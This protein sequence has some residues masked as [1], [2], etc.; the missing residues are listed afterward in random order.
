MEKI[1]L[2]NFVPKQIISGKNNKN[3]DINITDDEDYLRLNYSVD[4]H[5]QTGIVGKKEHYFLLPKYIERNHEMFEVLGLLQAEMGKTNNG[6][7]N[8]CN[9]EIEIIKKVVRWFEREFDFPRK[10]WKWYIK[11]NINEP[12]DQDYKKEVEDKVSNYWIKQIGLSLEQ[13][14]PKK[15]SYV[16]DTKNKKLKFYDYG[17]LIIERKLNLFS[18]IIKKLVKDI[19]QNILNYREEE[20]RSF[21]RGI[22]GG[23]SCIEIHKSSKKYRIHITSNH[24]EERDIYISCLNRL[25]IYSKQYNN[26]KD[27]IISRKENH[28]KLFEQ[29]LMCTSRKK[30]NKFLKLLKQYPDFYGLEKYKENMS[31]PHNKPKQEIIDKI[32]KLC[33]E[34]PDLSAIEIAK[35]VGISEY[36]VRRFRRKHFGRRVIPTPESKRKEITEF[37][38]QNPS[39]KKY[40]VAKYFNVHLAVVSRAVMSITIVL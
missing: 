21:M 18:Q 31:Y 8:F 19:T 11:V 40:E 38:K 33:K 27:L 17:T 6:C 29:N 28:L 15:V 39:L 30:Y 9:H 16:K 26:Y 37:V 2:T 14:Y 4:L 24:K 1:E 12:L 3:Y 32:L 5:N 13:S 36:S 20:I 10:G 34:K 35:I 7:L 22:I 25:G 23:E